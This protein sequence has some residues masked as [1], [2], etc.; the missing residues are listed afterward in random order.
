MK[1]G[2]D[3]KEGKGG[4]QGRKGRIPTKEGYHGWK[5]GIEGREGYQGRKGRI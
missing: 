4:Y 2:E 1:E 3:I 5:D